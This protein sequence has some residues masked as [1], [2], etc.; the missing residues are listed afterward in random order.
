M[1][2]YSFRRHFNHWGNKKKLGKA[3]LVLRKNKCSFFQNSVSYLG[4][5]IDENGLHK[6]PE[7][8]KAIVEAE[9]PRNV[10]ELKSF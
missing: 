6:S 5:I 10:S 8:I 3:G 7:K 2:C 1:E 9:R 4:F